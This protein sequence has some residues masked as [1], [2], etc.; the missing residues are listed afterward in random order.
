MA[1]ITGETLIGDVFKLKAGADEVIRRHLGQGCF[2]CPA[3]TTE[4]LSMAAVMHSIDLD[5]LLAELNALPDGQTDIEIGPGE[6]EGG[7]LS[8][9]LGRKKDK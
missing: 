8:G 3:V 2:T 9:L 7:F 5:T 4:A 1:E 6:R